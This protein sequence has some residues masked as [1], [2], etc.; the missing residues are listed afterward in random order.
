MSCS[1]L[2]LTPVTS[3]AAVPAGFQ[4]SGAYLS[5]EGTAVHMQLQPAP[6]DDAD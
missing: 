5:K 2:G 1:S 4:T 3:P 6:N